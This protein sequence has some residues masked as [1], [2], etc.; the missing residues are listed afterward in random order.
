MRPPPLYHGNNMSDDA[1]SLDLRLLGDVLGLAIS[2]NG[3]KPDISDLHIHPGL[4]IRARYR[5]GIRELRSCPSGGACPRPNANSVAAL[6]EQLAG[7]RSHIKRM[8]KEQGGADFAAEVP[9]RASGRPIR[10]RVNAYHTREGVALALRALPLEPPRLDDLGLPAEQLRSLMRPRGL[11][12]VVGATGSGKS[13]TL[14]AL[15]HEQNQTASPRGGKHIITIEDPIEVIHEPRAA[16]MSQREVGVHVPSFAEGVRQALRQDPDIIMV[17]EIRDSETARAALE[18]A[19]TGHL[20]LS[21]LHTSDTPSTL[22]RLLALFPPEER[23]EVRY[24]L[25]EN[26]LGILSQR[27]IPTSEGRIPIYEL[28]TVDQHVRELIEKG[29]MPALRDLVR[30]TGR[31]TEHQGIIGF[32][33]SLAERVASGKVSLEVAEE[34]ATSVANLRALVRQL[35]SGLASGAQVR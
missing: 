4:P 32:D 22:T 18:A 10:V 30:Q 12:L 1:P 33:R 5:G 13:T 17:G 35:R 2:K 24:G 27:L 28:F 6:L 26:L 19:R 7:G 20:V 9:S 16:I 8:L 11:F 25:A 15:I 3:K 29:D 21:T 34:Y 23:E 31:Q 14:A